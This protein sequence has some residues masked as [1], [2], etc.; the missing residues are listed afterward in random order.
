MTKMR[1]AGRRDW[2]IL[3]TLG[4]IGG[5]TFLGIEIALTDFPPLWVAALRIGLAAIFMTAVWLLRGGRLFLEPVRSG[6]RMLLP[7]ISLLSTVIPFSLISW[8]QQHV[9][10]GFAAVAMASSAL[11]VAPL[12]HF[13]VAHERLSGKRSVGLMTGFAGV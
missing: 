8:G 3:L 13:F 5:G 12:A 4:L 7:V 9:T 1:I 6:S 11:I 2:M 10:S